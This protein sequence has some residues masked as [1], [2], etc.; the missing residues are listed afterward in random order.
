MLRVSDTGQNSGR[1]IAERRVLALRPAFETFQR[2]TTTVNLLA[3]ARALKD[4]M[5]ID[6]RLGRES[7]TEL[8]TAKF[9]EAM[10]SRIGE[11]RGV[12]KI[13][14]DNIPLAAPCALSVQ[15]MANIC[16]SFE[17]RPQ[18]VRGL[19]FYL[20]DL[21]ALYTN[22]NDAQNRDNIGGI[23]FSAVVAGF[24]HFQR[25]VA[26]TALLSAQGIDVMIIHDKQPVH[27]L[28]PGKATREAFY[29][30]LRPDRKQNLGRVE[31]AAEY[32]FFVTQKKIAIDDSR[33]L[34]LAQL[35][36][37]GEQKQ[38]EIIALL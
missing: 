10:N 38:E 1:T 15:E 3:L 29:S 30:S 37:L 8:T 22:Y 12:E 17:G 20:T 31:L 34:M 26:Y 2:A 9:I 28:K 19:V 6:L 4:E 35:Y 32:L 11:V 36:E 23:D 14:G 5:A 25:I 21:V 13:H 27:S 16:L 33:D 18:A 24:L 7:L